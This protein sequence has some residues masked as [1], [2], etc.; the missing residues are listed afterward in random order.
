MLLDTTHRFSLSFLVAAFGE[1]EVEYVL[2]LEEFGS[3][4]GLAERWLVVPEL[5]RFDR[6]VS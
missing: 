3:L 4:V 1:S 6:F 2:E 5:S